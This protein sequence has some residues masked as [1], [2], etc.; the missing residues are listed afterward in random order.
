DARGALTLNRGISPGENSLATLHS[1]IGTVSIEAAPAD[2]LIPE[3]VPIHVLKIDV[4]G[5]EQKALRGMPRILN[6]PSLKRIFVEFSPKRQTE[7]GDDPKAL[8]ERLKECGFSLYY[9]NE[10]ERRLEPTTPAGALDLAE[11]QTL[12]MINVLA[13]K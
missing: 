13:K 2:S 11:S 1:S 7:A 3:D 10:R 6:S 4:E 5:W 12:K 9:M 8:L